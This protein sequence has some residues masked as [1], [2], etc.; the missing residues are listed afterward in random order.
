MSIKNNPKKEEK[1]N[2]IIGLGKSGFWAAKFLSKIGKRVIVWESN[3]NKKLLEIKKELEKLCIPVIL[4]Q[5]FLFDELFPYLNQIESVVVSPAIPFNHKTIIKLKERG[6]N[7]IG[8]INI[9]WESL[10]NINWI[11]ITGTNGKTTVTHLLSHILSKNK[12]FAP[13]AGNIGTPLSKLAFVGNKKSIDW[14]VAELSSYQI[15]IAPCV[16]PK[17]GI[18]TTFTADH[19]DR[20]KN[21]EIYF[22]IKNS[23][24]KQSEFRV[25]NYDDKYL[26]ANYKSLSKGIWI[27]TDS[28]EADFENC[29]YWINNERYIVERKEKLFSLKNF[30]LKG[31]HNAQ[32]LLL[33]VAAARKIGLSPEAI[34]DSLI[35]YRQLPHRLETIYEYK[36]LEI[37]N[38]SKATNFDASIAG[39]NAIKGD[40]VIISGGRLKNGNPNEWVKTINKRA[41][42]VF[43]FGESSQTLKKLIIH[44]GFKRD[45]LTFSDL[46]EVVEYSYSYLEKNKPET[47]LFSP[48]CSSFDQFRDYEE[49]GDI[50]KTLIH[51]KFNLTLFKNKN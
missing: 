15:E 13:F 5:Q 39:I 21:L 34:K 43:L 35:S 42:A 24:L 46:S 2:F 47:L 28:D 51:E 45:I 48:S 9:A 10:K 16:K 44:G 7:V 3:E 18:W 14:L 17:I 25:Y 49:R 26:R 40:P 6:I 19:L 8:E 30:K 27:T 36:N 23:L 37:I 1:I 38:D 11:G 50:F 20:H 33:A 12:L 32:N 22:K 29:D 31:N 41:K 4:N